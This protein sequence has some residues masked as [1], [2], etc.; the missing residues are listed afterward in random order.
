[1]TRSLIDL[2]FSSGVAM[3]LS[4]AVFAATTVMA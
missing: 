1:M 3:V 2:L 4:S